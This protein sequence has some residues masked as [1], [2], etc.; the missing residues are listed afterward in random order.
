MLTL[1]LLLPCVVALSFVGRVIADEKPKYL[2]PSAAV[3]ER[4]NDLLPRLTLDEKLGLVHAATKFT[5][6][7]VPRLGIPPVHMS[8]GP[9]GV[10][11]EISPTS[12]KPLGRTDDFCT[13]M[14][15]SIC[16]A[17]SWDPELAK[18]YGGVIADEARQRG[19]DIM[20]GPGVNIMR[21]PLNGRNFEYYGEDPWLA[22]RIV[23]G[24]VMGEQAGDVASCVKHYAINNQEFERGTVNVE[25]D[26]RALREIYLP[27][28]EA[29]V[30]EARAR[31]VMGAYNRYLGQHCCHNEVLVNQILKGEWGFQGVYLSDWG[32]VH[33]TREAALYGMDLEMGTG[34]PPAEMYLANPYKQQLESGALPM[35]TLDDKVRRIL[36]LI[37]VTKLIDGRPAGSINTTDHQNIARRVAEQ[38]I[39]LLKNQDNA[40]PL[41]PTKI[42]SIAVIGENATRAQAYGGWS[43][44]LKAFYEITPL[45]GIIARV[46]ERVNVTYAPGYLAP[47]IRRTEDADA[48][49]VKRTEVVK[50]A[51]PTK[52]ELI[53]Q[54]VAAA[55]QA[56]VVIYVGGLNHYL[57]LDSEGADKPNLRLPYE[58]DELLGRL[59]EANPRI[60]VVN[61]SGGP[62]E[63]D[64]WLERV[65]AVVQ[66]WYLGMEAGNALAAVLFGDV[67]PSG[68]LPC[69]FPR[70]LADS[71]AH[72]FGPEAY[73]GT[74]KNG[75]VRYREG[76][77][78]GYRWFDTKNI[79]PLFP[80]GFGL[81]YTQFAYSELRVSPATPADELGARAIVECDVANTGARAGAEVVQVYV[82]PPQIGDGPAKELRGFVKV[83]L[84]PG[85]KKRVTI[86]LRSRAFASYSPERKAWVSQKGAYTILVG[87]SSRDIRL[88]GA[89]EVPDEEVLR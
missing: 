32:G 51:R 27:A 82:A 4:I 75:T 77:L 15:V 52:D 30:K 53:A 37:F 71:P 14:P 39:V 76:L 83:A 89:F 3:E 74:G 34:K 6:A 23:V 81:S 5:N 25:V 10:R 46:G 62:V 11:E 68:K 65:P 33:D 29:A 1:R 48:A 64:P 19:K 40:L 26:E 41:D 50:V 87:A 80:F 84:Q 2:D 16:L 59:I 9:H 54:A 66:G 78:V 88:T 60:I 47:V 55:R 49:G 12:W 24:Y 57:G 13:Y 28:F 73:P 61:L 31:S 63:M 79:E 8:D 86:P 21:T 67:N 56:E 72:A 70:K 38:G 7:G 43:S 44:E 22:S 85:E 36:R 18:A 17:A 20:L 69:T 35:S 42:K 58:Q 45:Q